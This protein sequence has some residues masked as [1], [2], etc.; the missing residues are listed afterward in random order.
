MALAARAESRLAISAISFWEI[1]LLAAKGRLERRDQPNF[2]RSCSIAGIVELPVASENLDSCISMVKS[3]KDRMRNNVSE[4]LDWA[5]A[6]RILPERNVNS[7][8]I[9]IGAV[10]RKNSPKVL[11][12]MSRFLLNIEK[13]SLPRLMLSGDAATGK[14]KRLVLAEG[15]KQLRDKNIIE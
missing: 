11:L 6:G 12:R 9:V 15:I 14:P 2:E 5:C 13:R 3:R 8:F 7:Y 1:A 10:F 4:P